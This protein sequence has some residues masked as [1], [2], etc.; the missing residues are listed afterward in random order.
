MTALLVRGPR[1]LERVL[2][3]FTTRRANIRVMYVVDVPLVGT[4]SG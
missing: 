3:C 4:A 2:G 1:L